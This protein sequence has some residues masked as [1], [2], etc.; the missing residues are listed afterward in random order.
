MPV[1]EHVVNAEGDNSRGN[2]YGIT[3]VVLAWVT[4]LGLATVFFQEW[5]DGR[6]HPNRVVH[7]VVTDEIG[8]AHV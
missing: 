1:V 2:S 7:G 6:E 4:A 5:L 8:R 3:M